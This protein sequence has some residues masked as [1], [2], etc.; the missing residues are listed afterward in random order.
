MA[1]GFSTTTVGW[2][3]AIIKG[4]D[5]EVCTYYLT[6]TAAVA[7]DARSKGATLTASDYTAAIP[8]AS[9]PAKA[10]GFNIYEFD[11]STFAGFL[12]SVDATIVPLPDSVATTAGVITH[13]GSGATGNQL[14]Y[15]E[16][17]ADIASSHPTY[18]DFANARPMIMK[19][20]AVRAVGAAVGRL[21]IIAPSNV[22][23]KKVL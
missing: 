7:A 16:V 1:L 17:N 12:A 3:E 6:N 9:F 15:P 22:L 10:D 4:A 5:T 21:A 13:L 19:R 18:D 2:Q 8:A 11:E 23:C 14:L 20:F